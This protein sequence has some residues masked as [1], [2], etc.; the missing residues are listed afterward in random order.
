MMVCSNN[1]PLSLFFCF[2]FFY[3]FLPFPVCTFSSFVCYLVI[4]VSFFLILLGHFDMI[5]LGIGC[6][7]S[8]V[9]FLGLVYLLFYSVTLFVSFFV[10][11][12]VWLFL[13]EFANFV[14]C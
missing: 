2:S 10:W 12:F 4:V 1:H 3:Y 6:L 5:I 11:L 14:V 9:L 8:F 7:L 13:C